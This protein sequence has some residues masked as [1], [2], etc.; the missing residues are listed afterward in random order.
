MN[1]KNTFTR[2][3]TLLEEAEE[4]SL[5]ELCE[6]LTRINPGLIAGYS[7]KFMLDDNSCI[8][9]EIKGEN[10]IYLY[11]PTKK[12][13]IPSGYSQIEDKII[14]Y[15]EDV[16]I[17]RVVYIKMKLEDGIKVKDYTLYIDNDKIEREKKYV[18]SKLD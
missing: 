6:K 10:L 5:T 3:K 11:S 7:K 15:Y 18:Y 1:K 12:I 16:I 4:E 13:I 8:R 2:R 17:A 14:Y 9:E